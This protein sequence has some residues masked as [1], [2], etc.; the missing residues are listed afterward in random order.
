MRTVTCSASLRSKWKPAMC[1]SSKP[2]AHCSQRA[3]RDVFM[4]HRRMPSLIRATGLA[5]PR[6]PA[7]RCKIWNSGSSIRRASRARAFSLRKACAAKAG[8][9]RNAN[10]GRFME[11]FAPTLKDLAPRDF[12][13]RAM[14]QEIKEGRGCGPDKAYVLLDL[15]HIGAETIHKRLPSIREIALKFANVDC[16]REAIP[17]VPTIHYQMGGIP[18]NIHGQVIGKPGDC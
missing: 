5:W 1:T 13:S 12:V 3:A 10:G 6:A 9:L 7:S 4:R 16:V 18:T 14:D 11:R 17:V 15:S 8:F 2:N